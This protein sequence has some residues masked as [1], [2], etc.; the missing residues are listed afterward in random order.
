MCAPRV[1]LCVRRHHYSFVRNLRPYRHVPRTFHDAF[2]RR[3]VASQ[4]LLK[5]N[6]PKAYLYLYRHNRCCTYMSTQTDLTNTSSSL[7]YVH[8]CTTFS[9]LRYA[10]TCNVSMQGVHEKCGS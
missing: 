5:S 8:T 4:I 6:R 1:F 9:G 3:I 7:H 10:D 2:E